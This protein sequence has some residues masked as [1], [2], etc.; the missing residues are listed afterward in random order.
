MKKHL[1][2]ILAFTAVLLCTSVAQAQHITIDGPKTTI[3]DGS[4]LNIIGEDDQYLYIS[5]LKIDSYGDD[6]DIFISVYDKKNRSVVIEH[7]IDEDH[8]FKSAYMRGSDVVL[9]GTRYNGKTKSVEFFECAF[10]VMMKTPRKFVKTAVYSVP[11]SSNKVRR[12][13]SLRSPDSTK[14]AYVTCIRL[15]GRA[16]GGYLLDVEVRDANGGELSHFN[17]QYPNTDALI[18]KAFLSNSGTVFV[19]ESRWDLTKTYPKYLDGMDYYSRLS[20]YYTIPPKGEVSCYPDPERDKA[21]LNACVGL[22]HNGNLLVVGQISEGWASVAL[23]AEG[24]HSW[25]YQYEGKIP[26]RPENIKY[27]RD[28]LP[29]LTFQQVIPLSEGRTLVMAY[30]HTKYYIYNYDMRRAYFF[31]LYQTIYLYMFDSKG[32]LTASSMIPFSTQSDGDAHQNK[33]TAFLWNGEVWLIFNGNYE[34]YKGTKTPEEWKMLPPNRPEVRCIVMGRVDGELN[35]EPNVI[36]EQD[37]VGLWNR[38]D[39]YDQ[40]VKVDGDKIYSIIHHDRSNH[41]EEISQ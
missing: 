17:R 23:D 3:E 4:R 6:D 10:P 27:V 24:E 35:F 32:K 33:P 11:C 36:Y 15:S 2:N 38:G 12:T 1:S 39:Y 30:R 31:N 28:E 40:L 18:T 37:G 5:S 22:L 25:E 9:E 14:T 19:E 29:P 20:R 8:Y 26:D 13:F 41:I 16:K 21:L 34:N 7:R